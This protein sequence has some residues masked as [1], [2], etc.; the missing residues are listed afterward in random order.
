[1][2]W[3]ASNTD[4]DGERMGKLPV[5]SVPP[6]FSEICFY[7]DKGYGMIIIKEPFLSGGLYETIQ[8][9]RREAP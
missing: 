5:S 2:N 9:Y 3:P 4:T 8:N 1:M 6:T 7:K